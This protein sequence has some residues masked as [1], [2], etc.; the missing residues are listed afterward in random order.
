MMW[1]T[2]PR[3]MSSFSTR[4][5][6]LL[7][8]CLMAAA[9]LVAEQA[10][11]ALAELGEDGAVIEDRGGSVRLS[12]PLTQSVPWRVQLMDGPP[13]LVV[14]FN[15]LAWSSA[16]VVKSDSIARVH[17]G[18]FTP[19]WSRLVA[20]LR[21]PLAVSVAEMNVDPDG[22]AQLDILLTPTT[23]GE[24]RAD[25]DAENERTPALTF[26]VKDGLP[27][28]VIDPGHGGIDPGAE[29]EGLREADLMLAFA[30]R[31]A[32]VLEETG[33][34]DV[35]LTR[36]E[37]FFVPL[38]D[39]LSVARL[40]GAD[41]F[42][43]LHADA[44]EPDAGPASGMSVYTLSDEF[45]DAAGQ[46]MAERH[47]RHNILA[48]VDLSETGD[49]V[50]LVLMEMA[51]RETTPRA[52]MLQD[53]VVQSFL[54]AGLAVNSRPERHGDFSVLKA[55]DIPS[56]L[57]ELGFLSSDADRALFASEVWLD[58]ASFAIRDALLYWADE[59]RL[60]RAAMRR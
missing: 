37:D 8:C 47:A 13:R 57:I 54:S 58:E 2:R 46:R 41:V 45:S 60:M 20:V 33:R 34:F 5:G 18:R 12:V 27:L 6:A 14:D 53:K 24:F 48:G 38:E 59:D 36:M 32:G 52:A 50:A 56:V 11:N 25:A 15:E 23:A 10:A 29:V 39:R 3:Q 7:A 30:G 22:M 51:R 35:Y 16:P 31:L 55:A 1:K 43:S 26:G 4:I 44:L 49:D 21:E 40:A 42:L 28:V 17:V 9:P 19:G